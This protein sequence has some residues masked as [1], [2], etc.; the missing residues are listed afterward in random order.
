MNG[1][2][3]QI[4]GVVNVHT[5][6]RALLV[7]APS[8]GAALVTG[9]PLWMQ[10]ALVTASAFIAMEHTG[11]A[12]LGVALHGLAIAAGLL[13]LVA[14]LPFPPLFAL[15]VAAMAAG[16]ILL[17]AK[18]DR[19]RALGNFTFIPALYLAYELGGRGGAPAWAAACAF[20]PYA[21]LAVLPVLLLSA[22]EC[23][24][25]R[26]PDV[27]L[28][29][30]LGRI[31]RTIDYG[32]TGPWVEAAI[33]VALAVASAALL[34]G[35]RPVP[36][37]QWV[38]WSAASVV[39]GDAAGA[40]RKMGDRLAGVLT[41]APIGIICALLT[42]EAP[43][44]L[45]PAEIGAVLTLMAF[46]IYRLGFGARCACIAFSLTVAGQP[47]GAADRIANVVL[48]GVIGLSFVLVVHAAAVF[49]QRR[50]PPPSG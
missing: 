29:A 9:D 18:G 2:L 5:L 46:R 38:V 3:R 17:T 4:D 10:A 30:H 22:V 20:L 26:A 36:H 39:T 41:G 37:A 25:E 8:F 19:L 33:A 31:R 14:T 15:A 40:R 32:A 50:S 21:A 6:A 42:P 13:I 24:R 28:R 44:L 23:G 7:L 34:V 47:D 49:L 11:L 16:T 48:G 35:W 45:G 27:S 43:L 12:P 1:L